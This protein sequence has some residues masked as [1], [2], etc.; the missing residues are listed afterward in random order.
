MGSQLRCPLSCPLIPCMEVVGGL[1]CMAKFPRAAHGQPTALPC[2]SYLEAVGCLLSCPL[3]CPLFQ[4][5]E[6]VSQICMAKF[7]RAAHSVAN[8]Q[9]MGREVG[10]CLVFSVWVYI[11]STQKE[12]HHLY[13]FTVVKNLNRQ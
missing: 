6:V 4:Y 7:T 2:F 8:V 3:R 10:S 5:M 13:E 1:I 12:T 11:Y 9:P